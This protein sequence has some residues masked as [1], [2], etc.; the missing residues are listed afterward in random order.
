MRILSTGSFLPEKILSNSDLER[1]V[2]TS[3]EWIKTRTGVEERRI[4]GPEEAT[5]DL[6]AAACRSALEKA[7]LDAG[8]V[9]AVIT[10]T[11]TPDHPLPAAACLVQEKIGARNAF[12]FDLSAACSGFVYGLV[13]AN[14]LIRS[15]TCRH[16]LLVAAETMSRITDYTDRRTCILLGD[17]AGAVLLGPGEPGALLGHHLGSDGSLKD[18]LYVPAGGSR[19]PACAE[20]VRERLHYLKM[21]GQAIFRIAV[22]AM[23]RA[24]RLAIEQSGLA[25]EE[26]DLVVPH[27][28]NLR[29]INAVAK[30]LSIGPEKI[31]VNI[32]K[33]G[34]MSAASIAVAFDEALSGGRLAP[35]SRALLFSFGG[36]LTWGAALLE[37]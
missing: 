17:G 10:A 9:D 22:P 16:V 31:L 30:N 37:I 13:V 6:G 19:R 26:I 23:T 14:G 11:V 2:D 5:S 27:Q 35:G 3:D 28:A 12:A 7:G 1:M 36:G 25:P 33:Y 20:T 32:Q 29:I 34:N 21:E 4:A 8:E 15:G 18:L 24:S